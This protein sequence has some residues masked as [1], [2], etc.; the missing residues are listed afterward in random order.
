MWFERPACCFFVLISAGEASL[1]LPDAIMAFGHFPAQLDSFRWLKCDRCQL[2]SWP[3]LMMKAH[4]YAFG[5]LL[6]VTRTFPSSALCAVNTSRWLPPPFDSSY[7]VFDYIHLLFARAKT[8]V[9][10]CH[11]SLWIALLVSLFFQLIPHRV[12]RFSRCLLP[13]VSPRLPLTDSLLAQAITAWTPPSWHI[14]TTKDRTEQEAGSYAYTAPSILSLLTVI[15]CVCVCVCV[16]FCDPSANVCSCK[17]DDA[18]AASTNS[19]HS[20]YP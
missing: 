8:T 2:S 15:Q 12:P 20:P 13:P 9:R 19:G 10:R 7:S 3:L 14:Y 11:P 4:R 1:E 6:T 5:R 16:V 17:C 18:T